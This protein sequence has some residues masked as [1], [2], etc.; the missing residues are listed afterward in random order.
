LDVACFKPFK[1]A[2]RKERDITM[3]RKNYIEPGEIT[4]TG[5]VDKALHLTLTRKYHV[6]VQ[7]YKDLA[8]YP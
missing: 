4:L 7:R 8:I 2:L 6:E 3:V 1:I 5:W